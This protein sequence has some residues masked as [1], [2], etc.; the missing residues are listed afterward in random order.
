[1]AHPTSNQLRHLPI[2][3]FLILLSLTFVLSHCDTI[4]RLHK[5][6]EGVGV[7]AERTFHEGEIV[8]IEPMVSIHM[9]F[10]QRSMIDFYASSSWD[11]PEYDHLIFGNA[12]VYNHHPQPNLIYSRAIMPQE[13]PH[14]PIRY[15]FTATREIPKGSEMF[16]SYGTDLWFAHRNI[17][18]IAPSVETQ[19]PDLLEMPKIPGCV[20]ST[21]FFSKGNLYTTE[22]ISAGEVIQV[23][24]AIVIPGH[25]AIGNDLEEYVWFREGYNNIK[26]ALLIIGG[27]ALFNTSSSSSGPDSSNVMYSWYDPAV[28]SLRPEDHRVNVTCSLSMMVMF[29]ASRDIEA[30][31]KLS[32]PLIRDSTPLTIRQEGEELT[33]PKPRVY[34]PVKRKMIYDIYLPGNC[35]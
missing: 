14:D 31:E 28:D 17:E 20:R 9:N 2:L 16:I 18:M 25:V 10:S 35:F 15:V 4:L 30:N 11:R 29:V 33:R 3:S 24:R 19:E 12:L 26:G 1:M 23:N 32:L 22:K 13:S 34:R 6:Y 7:F 21:V 5:T 8:A 27:G